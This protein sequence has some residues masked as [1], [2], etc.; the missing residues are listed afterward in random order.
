MLSYSKPL[1]LCNFIILDLVLRTVNKLSIVFPRSATKSHYSKQKEAQEVESL[2]RF[3]FGIMKNFY[4]TIQ[5]NTPRQFHFASSI[6]RLFEERLER[7]FD[8]CMV[9]IEKQKRSMTKSI[10]TIQMPDTELRFTLQFNEN[11]M[12]HA[13]K[14]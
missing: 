4:K 12:A 11:I 3:W 8:I 13:R 7:A 10:E 5:M 14:V 6:F 9:S 2:A 1:R